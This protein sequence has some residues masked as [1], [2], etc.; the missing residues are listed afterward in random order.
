MWI[1]FANSS[2]LRKSVHVESVT[3]IDI[4][5]CANTVTIQNLSRYGVG[6]FF[7]FY[8]ATSLHG[9]YQTIS[10]LELSISKGFPR[11]STLG[12]R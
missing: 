7:L 10:A 4:I 8:N 2:L 12:S 3:K 1:L 5:K 6:D 9:N 11:H